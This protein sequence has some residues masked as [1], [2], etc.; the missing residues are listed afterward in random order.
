[1]FDSLDGLTTGTAEEKLAKVSNITEY[2][3]AQLY[4][5]ETARSSLREEQE[6]TAKSLL[7]AVAWPLGLYGAYQ[8]ASAVRTLYQLSGIGKSSREE[9]SEAA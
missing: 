3:A 1:M 4:A 7:S 2:L 5:Q 8:C 9:K 6:G